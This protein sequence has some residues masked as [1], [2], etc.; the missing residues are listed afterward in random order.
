MAEEGMSRFRDEWILVEGMRDRF[1]WEYWEN[2]MESDWIFFL[3]IFS[4][5]ENFPVNLSPISF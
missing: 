4:F 5:L 1:D 3:N 2:L